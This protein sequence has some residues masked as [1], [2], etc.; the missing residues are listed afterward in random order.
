MEKGLTTVTTEGVPQGGNM[1]PLLSNIMLH[2]LDTE[3]ERRGQRF[4]R[5]AYDCDVYEKS[6]K[7][8]ERVMKSITKF[9]DLKFKSK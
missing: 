2:V 5:Y 6:R 1:S 4:C 7:S 9:E 8:A 3:L